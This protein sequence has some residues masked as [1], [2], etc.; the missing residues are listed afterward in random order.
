MSSGDE[1]DKAFDELKDCLLAAR[2]HGRPILRAIA[3]FLH[4]NFVSDAAYHLKEIESAV[5]DK[6]VDSIEQARKDFDEAKFLL[7]EC[8]PCSFQSQCSKCLYYNRCPDHT[9][10]V[11]RKALVDKT[12]AAL[13]KVCGNINV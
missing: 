3:K 2:E 11:V 5:Y 10:Y 8:T 6:P 12:R 4:C 13:E 7:M 1:F 9:Q